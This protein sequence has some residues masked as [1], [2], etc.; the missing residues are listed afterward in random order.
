MSPQNNDQQT[1]ASPTEDETNDSASEGTE[2]SDDR[3]EKSAEDVQDL[4]GQLQA[5]VMRL[6]A[7]HAKE[8]AQ[9]W[10][11]RRPLLAVT[12]A[13]VTGAALGYGAAA[14]QRTSP[15]TL[16]EHAQNRLR[17]LADEVRQ[18]T[19]EVGR[20]LTD[21]AAKSGRDW[22][23]RAQKTGRRLVKEARDVAQREAEDL[24]NRA[25]ERICEGGQAASKGAREF[26]ANV[27][28]RAKKKAGEGVEFAREAT[29]KPT[30]QSRLKQSLWSI[31]GLTIAGY[32]VSK[33]SDSK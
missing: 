20:E 3:E 14:A 5:E 4:L 15:P 8:Q 12:L 33:W 18:A 23:Q 27:A 24:A 19:S 26:G 6:R 17:E 9:S 31:A 21:R 30:S 7:H 16:S 25:S 2:F 29:S 11:Q 22:S 10:I 32:L 28:N 1:E 13:S